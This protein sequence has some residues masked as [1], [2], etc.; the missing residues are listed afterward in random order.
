VPGRLRVRKVDME[1]ASEKK[2]A[3]HPILAA[4]SPEGGFFSLK[5]TYQG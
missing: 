5:P 3:D 2:G 4:G 1:T